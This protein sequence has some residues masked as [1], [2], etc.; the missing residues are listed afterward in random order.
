MYDKHNCHAHTIKIHC[1]IHLFLYS[2]FNDRFMMSQSLMNSKNGGTNYCK[3]SILCN[4]LI[5][6]SV[7]LAPV[8]KFVVS[9]DLQS[10][11]NLLSQ[12]FYDLSHIFVLDCL[13]L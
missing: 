9:K 2:I 1:I 7:L 12:N 6:A 3:F 8:P 5:Y 4:F 11:Q 13:P 10:K